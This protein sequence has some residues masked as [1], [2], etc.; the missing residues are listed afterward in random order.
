MEL[1]P[2][3][4][5]PTKLGKFLYLALRC[6]PSST[7][8]ST[9]VRRDSGSEDHAYIRYRLEERVVS[10]PARGATG[11]GGRSTRVRT[12]AAKP[13]SAGQKST[14]SIF[15]ATE[16]CQGRKGHSAVFLRLFLAWA[17]EGQ[18]EFFRPVTEVSKGSTS[19]LAAWYAP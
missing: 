10:E 18:K 15:S 13:R 17:K 9:K 11:P 4:E 12:A 19:K 16:E 2:G 7:S 5:H 14:V 3:F 8:T 1:N 6:N